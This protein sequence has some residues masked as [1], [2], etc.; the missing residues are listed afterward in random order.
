ME[1]N[2]DYLGTPG[3]T[4][5]SASQVLE[6]QQD[7][8]KTKDEAAE[9]LEME[10]RPSYD[11]LTRHVL[12]AFYTHRNARRE[13]NIEQDM[14]DDL[15]QTSGSYRPEEIEDIS[16]SNIFMNITA[17]KQRAAKSWIQDIVTPANS[18]PFEVQTSKTEDIPPAIKE[19]IF[20]ALLEDEKR[21]AKEI[22]DKYAEMAKKASGEGQEGQQGP[23]EENDVRKGTG[24]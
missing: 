4:V 24:W 15:Y 22:E 14:I 6:E 17:T 2:Y 1:E 10:S 18:S 16:G 20:D 19:M 3:V 12:D 8:Q 7:E 11:E 9:A 13:S 5:K 21:L 23:S